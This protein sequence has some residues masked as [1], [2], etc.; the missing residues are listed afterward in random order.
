MWITY[1]VLTQTGRTSVMR[2]NRF[3]IGTTS[4]Y[5]HDDAQMYPLFS[6]KLIRMFLSI[7]FDWKDINIWLNKS[8]IVINLLKHLRKIILYPFRLL[9]T[10]PTKEVNGYSTQPMYMADQIK[11]MQFLNVTSENYR[12]FMFKRFQIVLIDL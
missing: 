2:T 4:S 8:E 11:S 1:C 3:R 6:H 7:D 10:P 12:F 5:H 9:E